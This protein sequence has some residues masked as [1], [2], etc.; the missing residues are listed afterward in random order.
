MRIFLSLLASSLVL[1]LALPAIAAPDSIGSAVQLPGLL[2][3][4]QIRRDLHD[5]PHIFARN[6]RDALFALGRAHARDRF[7][8]MDV[9]RHQFSGTLAELAGQAGLASDVQLRTLGL[10]RA[11][12]ASLPALSRDTQVWLEA[13]ARGVNS[14]IFDPANPLPPEYG[15]LEL[16]RSSIHPWTPVDSVVIAKGL[17]FGLSFDLGDI[18]LTLAASAYALAGTAGGFNGGALFSQDV[19]R[20]A[21]FDPTVSIPGALPGAAAAGKPLPGTLTPR[22]LELAR[23]YRDRIRD[24]PLLRTALERNAAGHGSNW[25]VASGAVTGSGRPILAND[26]HLDL[27]TPSIFYEAQL[28]IAGG[29]RPAMNAFGVTFPG[30]PAIVLG[31]NVSICWGATT[32]PMDVTDVY[33]E[34]LVLDPA[35]GLPTHTVFNGHQEAIVF[36]PQTFLVNRLDGVP[37]DLADAGLGPL[38]GGVTL[39]VPRRNNGP[40]VEIDLSDPHNPIA[41]SIQYTGW[42]ATRELDAFRTW[43]RAGNLAQFKQG[44]QWFDA[45]SQNWSYADIDGNIAYF[46]SA[47]MPLREDLQ[48]LERADGG[49]P[50]WLIRDGTHTLKHEWLPAVS[51]REPGQ[52]LPY[53]I[54]PFAEMP[55]TVNPARGFIA[56]ANN[57]P[58]GTSN[59]NNPLNQRRS[60]GGLFYLGIGYDRGYRIG[61]IEKLLTAD[62]QFGGR[63]SQQDIERIQA[64]NQFLDA[65]ALTPQLL[66]AYNR[67]LAPGAPLA[68]TVLANDPRVSEAISRLRSWN[69]STPTGIPEGWDPG[70]DPAA[71][72]QPTQ[73][74]IRN[75]VAATIYSVWRGQIVG[76]VIDATLQRLGLGDF[77]PPGDVALADLRH[78]LDTFATTQGKGASGINFFFVPNVTS[79]TEARDRI[80]LS[81]LSDALGRLAS[82][83]FQAA[84]NGSLNQEDY[85]WGK[86]HRI[87]FEHL[88]GGPFNIPP[89]GGLSDLS[90]DLP[91]LARAGG[92]GTVDA[93]A[94]SVRADSTEDFRFGSGPARRFVGILTPEGPIAEEV[95]PGGTSGIP[96][97]PFQTDQLRLWLTNHYHNWVYRPDDVVS[98][99]VS[100][101]ELLPL[102]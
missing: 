99:T 42:G 94:H 93:A 18:D 74:E 101:E 38:Q 34:K 44:L 40:I 86:L 78:L 47:E 100:G 22:T 12:E 17:A 61:R 98:G 75:S 35:T 58:V 3:P 67:A 71:L 66:A 87:T 70:D 69:Y 64:N 79:A 62:L 102:P 76:A 85:R 91:G 39:V 68:L 80:L 92:F 45:G 7:F 49:V 43:N 57:D 33:Q 28:R 10:R 52:A 1:F 26:P 89:G 60:Q 20:A 11:A 54:L 97:S 2:A 27:G 4:V 96:G 5:V 32:N 56:N 13:Y 90:P 48:T 95:I 41:L 63:L 25:W 73:E 21:P 50:P 14:Y 37:D 23:R 65:E 24:V 53:R 59:D 19:F 9:L 84:F 88:L 16:T 81:C 51:P 8:Q 82:S 46:T 55:Q 30:I 15:A 72:P 31:C 83:S 77:L 6:D 36:I 29:T